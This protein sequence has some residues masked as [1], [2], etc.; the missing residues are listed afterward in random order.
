MYTGPDFYIGENVT[1]WV[2]ISLYPFQPETSQVCGLVHD[3]YTGEP[4]VNADIIVHWI[5]IHRQLNNKGSHTDENGFYSI[6]IGTGKFSVNTNTE[7]YIDQ[8]FGWIYIND[9]ETVWVNFS[10]DP[11]LVV[12][13]LKPINGF[14]YKNK[15]VFPFY[16]PVIIGSVD[17]EINATYFGGNP[18][19]H[20]EIK[21]DNSSKYNFTSPPYV[22]HWD[23]K[24][25]FRFH[26]TIE[27][28]VHR[29]YDSEAVKKLQVWKFF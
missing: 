25:L 28:T 6:R 21:I 9:Y 27:V 4:I 3:N 17:I 18:I 22:Y 20:V 16:F 10:L 11:E 13:I 23:E 29:N 14:Y 8:G 1:I 2:N 12:E 15:M 19:D 26:H 24:T 5:D 7:A